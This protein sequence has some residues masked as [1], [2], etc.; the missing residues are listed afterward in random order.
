M[1]GRALVIEPEAA[2]DYQVAANWYETQ[3]AGLALDFSREIERALQKITLNPEVYPIV[4]KP[5]GARRILVTRFPFKVV[6]LVGETEIRI[7]AIL[8]ASQDDWILEHRIR[9]S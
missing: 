2:E 8:H 4:H 9:S 7:K 5:S 6:Y 1:S 3:A